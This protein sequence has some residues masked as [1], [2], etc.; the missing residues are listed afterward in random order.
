MMEQEMKRYI[1]DGRVDSGAASDVLSAPEY[2][3]TPEQHA[4]LENQWL[5]AKKVGGTNG[6]RWRRAKD[7]LAARKVHGYTHGL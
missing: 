3:V 5:V 4:G 2:M 6:C 1:G 7:L